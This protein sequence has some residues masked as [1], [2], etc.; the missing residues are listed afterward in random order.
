MCEGETERK[1]V[2]VRLRRLRR[3]KENLTLDDYIYIELRF[4]RVLL[5][6]LNLRSPILFNI[7]H[8][9]NLRIYLRILETH[10]KALGWLYI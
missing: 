5:C 10:D 6:Q 4:N 8:S 2:I 1:R 7:F 3:K 9:E